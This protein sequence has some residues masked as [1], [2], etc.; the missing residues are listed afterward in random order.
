[1]TSRLIPV[2]RKTLEIDQSN[3]KSYFENFEVN[4]SSENLWDESTFS[5][6]KTI[7]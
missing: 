7:S 5:D 4:L 6:T 1:M 3:V 2:N